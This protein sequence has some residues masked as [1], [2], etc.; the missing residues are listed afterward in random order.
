[1]SLIAG[2]DE[3]GRGPLIGAVVTAAVILPEGLLI[4]GLRDSKKLSDRQR[5]ALVDQ[6]RT[7][8]IAYA[9]GRAEPAEID[10]L[11]I[12]KATLLAMQRAVQALSVRPDAVVVDG[13]VAPVLEMPVQALIGGDDRVL[14]ISAASVLA[15]VA[16]DDEMIALDQ[17][18]PGYGFARNKGYPT[19]EHRQAMMQLGVLP[20]HRRS[21]AP[22]ANA[23]RS[24]GTHGR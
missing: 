8:A 13:S 10:A 2:V 7:Q 15:K 14:A 3:V 1:M 19:A 16:R 24:G 22:V 18:Y 11:N 4:A 9:Y 5:R 21:F 17:R 20:E 23:L 6:I 12:L